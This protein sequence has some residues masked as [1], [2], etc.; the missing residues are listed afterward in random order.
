MDPS[1]QLPIQKEKGPFQHAE[2][3]CADGKGNGIGEPWHQRK[4]TQEAGKNTSARIFRDTRTMSTIASEPTGNGLD[5]T[6]CCHPPGYHHHRHTL[7]TE[8]FEAKHPRAG[9][10]TTTSFI[11]KAH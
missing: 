3:H 9:R 4:K 6:L 8:E 11:Q 1:E 10:P 2:K 7:I 5:V